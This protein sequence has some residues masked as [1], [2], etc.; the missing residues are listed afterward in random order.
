MAKVYVR[1]GVRPS[2]V[3][4]KAGTVRIKPGDAFEEG[5]PIVARHPHWFQKEGEPLEAADLPKKRTRKR[6][7][8]KKQAP[9]PVEA[10]TAEPGETRD[11]SVGGEDSGDDEDGSE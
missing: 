11:I 3:A 1:P 2:I 5:A 10:A 6:T 4:V 8:R 7:S 9:E